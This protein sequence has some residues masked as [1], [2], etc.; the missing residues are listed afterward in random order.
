MH[1]A[2]VYVVGSLLDGRWVELRATGFG[3]A[4]V[5][6]SGEPLGFGSGT[7]AEWVSTAAA[8]EAW[9]LQEVLGMCP[10]TPEMPTGCQTL[11]ATIEVAAASGRASIDGSLAR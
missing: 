1:G 5:A 9:V 8:A 4:V 7:P 3:L 10:A 2:V 11:I 6:A